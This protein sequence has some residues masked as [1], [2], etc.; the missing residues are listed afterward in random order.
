MLLWRFL[1]VAQVLLMQPKFLCFLSCLV[2]VKPLFGLAW[3]TPFFLWAAVM[4]VLVQ[5]RL[6]ALP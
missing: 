3:Q 5:L 1:K 6:K 2:F 4:D